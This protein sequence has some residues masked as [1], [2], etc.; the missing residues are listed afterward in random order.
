MVKR[1]AKVAG[2]RNETQ[3]KRRKLESIY[4]NKPWLTLAHK[5]P[6]PEWVAYNPDN[7][8]PPPLPVSVKFMKLLLWN[9]NGLHALMKKDDK[10]LTKLAQEEHF[11]VIC[12]TETK[13]QEKQVDEIHASIL[14]PEYKHSFWNCSSATPGFA[15]TAIISKIEPLSVEY[16]MGTSA[17]D[18]EGRVITAEF[19]QFHLVVGYVHDS[20]ERLVRWGLKT[21]DRHPSLSQHLKALEKKKPVIYAG[22]MNCA[23]EDIDISNPEGKS[24]G[25]TKE[26]REAFKTDFLK[27]GFVDT[28]RHQ[29]PDVVAYTYWPYRSGARARNNGW[30]VDYFLASQGLMNQVYD[31]YIRPEVMGSDHCPIGLIVKLESG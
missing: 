1:R 30:R 5:K 29:H 24:A 25:F 4:S 3:T 10:C 20:W 18:K 21:D 14:P 27:K 17:L 31:S 16:G 12:L 13:L 8:R 7:M 28:F 2:A 9:V 26:A 19:G 22:D 6:R 23:N 11:D 15:G